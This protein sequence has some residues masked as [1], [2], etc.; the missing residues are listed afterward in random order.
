MTAHTL[1]LPNGE[2]VEFEVFEHPHRYIPITLALM[3][4][5]QWVDLDSLTN[6]HWVAQKRRKGKEVPNGI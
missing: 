4:W 3:D 1:Q 2:R 6:L 5:L